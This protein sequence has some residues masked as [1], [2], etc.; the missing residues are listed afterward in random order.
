MPEKEELQRP[1]KPQDPNAKKKQETALLIIIIIIV[2]AALFIFYRNGL[3]G[4]NAAQ[5]PVE[6]YLTAI[7]SADFDS[8]VSVMP[9]KI[10]ADHISDR[11]DLN[12]SGEEYMKQLYADYFTEFGEDMTV[13]VDFTGKSRPDAVYVDN[14]KRSYLEVYGEEIEMSSVFEIDATA[15]FQG[16]N[17]RD[18]IDLEFFVIKTK[19]EWKVVGADYKTEDANVEE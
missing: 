10:A 16:S 9:E 17:S 6:K 4:G 13:T 18:N 19:G 3:L 1:K 2:A 8:F 7:C 14:F 11:N 5:K 15:H 12:L